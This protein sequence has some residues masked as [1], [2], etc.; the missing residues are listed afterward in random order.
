MRIK[1]VWATTASSFCADCVMVLDGASARWQD[2]L[3]EGVGFE[4]TEPLRALRFSRPVHSAAMRPLPEAILYFMV[5]LAHNA[6]QARVTIMADESPAEPVLDEASEQDEQQSE[7]EAVSADPEVDGQDPESDEA[8]GDPETDDAELQERRDAEVTFDWQASEYVQH[9]KGA[10]WY[11]AM[12]AVVLILIGFAVLLRYWLE[13]AAF[14]AM[15]GAIVVYARRAPR[16]LTYELT[17]DGITVDG[18]KM[19]FTTFRSFGVISDVEWHTIDLV[20]TKRF[21]TRLAILFEDADFDTI[22]G[23]LELHL[24]RVDREPDVVERLTRILRF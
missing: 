5:N 16:T 12:G 23:H 4:P 13:V 21:S 2:Y 6:S 19:P 22:I 17:R 18:V 20:P 15:G 7:D 1:V 8:E 11:M 9:H 24:P 10:G 14:V 3:A